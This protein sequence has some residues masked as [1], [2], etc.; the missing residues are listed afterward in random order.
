MSNKRELKKAIR[1]ICSELFGECASATLYCE[2]EQKENGEALLTSIVAMNNNFICRVSHPEPG[3]KQNEYFKKLIQDFN[4][5]A[6]AIVDQI[7]TIA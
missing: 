7:S 4:K 2:N 5:Q 6:S 1:N 3:M